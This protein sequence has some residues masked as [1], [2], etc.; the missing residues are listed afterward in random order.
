MDNKRETIILRT[1][2]IEITPSTAVMGSKTYGISI[3]RT[4]DSEER[5]MSSV[6]SRVIMIVSFPFRFCKI[7]NIR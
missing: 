4:A 2:D 7:H 5:N 1:D 3:I 6:A